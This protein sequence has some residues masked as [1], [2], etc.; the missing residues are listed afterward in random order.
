MIKIYNAL[1]R[2]KE[3][4]TEQER[5]VVKFYCCGP[6]VYNY[7]HIGNAR[8]I[9]VC[10][11]IRRYLEH[12]GFRV[13]YVQNFTDIDD[14]IINRANEAG[15]DY[16]T[17]SRKYIAE[18]KKDARGLNVREATV[19]PLAT[20]NIDYVLKMIS[21]LIDK[22]YAYRSVSGDVYFDVAKFKDYGKLSGQ[23]I[24]D[25]ESGARVEIDGS[26]RNPLDFVLWKKAKVGEPFWSSP[27]GDGRPGWHIECSA[28]IY[29]Y[30]GDT[31]DIHF[32]G[33]DLIFP[34]HENEIAQSE[35]FSGKVL[36]NYWMHN[37]Y[38]N[39][40][41]Q[42]MSKS[43]NNFFT[44]REISEKYGYDV[45]RFFMLSSHYRSP[46]NYSEEVLEQCKRSLE[47]L[48]T[49]RDNL[50]FLRDRSSGQKSLEAK[51]LLNGLLAYR[52]EFFKAM[53]DDFNTADAI[54]ALFNLT[55]KINVVVADER[56]VS[57]GFINE[58]IRIF[59]ELCGIL[60]IAFA[61]KTGKV[62]KGYV[63]GLIQKREKARDEKNWE[64][65]DALR[66]E[67]KN[68]GVKLED[69]AEGV[70]WSFLD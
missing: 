5:G 51:E 22:G 25:L 35:C 24:K 69:T 13:I 53:D 49:C 44:V 12:K 36:A 19:H 4:F 42:K 58:A 43:L 29:R 3:N 38:I 70:R 15:T 18:Y 7:I 45:I 21:G 32:G 59:D 63:E 47:R 67:L 28:M 34:H 2:K 20:E 16:L 61:S 54:S 6:T 62:S 65:A 64:L 14:K 52:E 66:D 9:C 37:G 23:S 60:G 46:L 30:L 26:K 31:V 56:Q 57:L 41:N 55:K 39:V 50:D 10:D 68:I 40:N 17:I 27:F 33:Q 11:V 48:R 1:I 8:P